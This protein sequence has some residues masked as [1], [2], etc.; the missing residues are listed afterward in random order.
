MQRGGMSLND[1]I[2]EDRSGIIL[3]RN[4][5]VSGLVGQKPGVLSITNDQFI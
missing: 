4:P 5:M 1:T 3:S 2:V